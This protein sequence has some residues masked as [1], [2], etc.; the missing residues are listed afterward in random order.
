M[1]DGQHNSHGGGVRAVAPPAPINAVSLLGELHDIAAGWLLRCP[2]QQ[3]GFRCIGPGTGEGP[4]C[5]VGHQVMPLSVW[6]IRF[7]C[8]STSANARLRSPAALNP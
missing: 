8:D 7:E 3:P 4:E 6:R 5:P 1:N 2:A